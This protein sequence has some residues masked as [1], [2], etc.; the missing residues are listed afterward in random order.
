MAC[1]MPINAWQVWLMAV[2]S[3]PG[4]QKGCSHRQMFHQVGCGLVCHAG[5]GKRTLE[6]GVS[7]SAAGKLGMFTWRWL[8]PSGQDWLVWNADEGP[9][10]SNSTLR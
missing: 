10:S 4:A 6:N 5:L 2:G 9:S 7:E 3:M 1:R 8:I